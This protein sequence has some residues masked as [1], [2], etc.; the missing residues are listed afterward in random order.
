MQVIEFQTQNK[1]IWYSCHPLG[2]LCEQD[3]QD[4]FEEFQIQQEETAPV[5][6]RGN[7]VDTVEMEQAL[8]P[9][10]DQLKTKDVPYYSTSFCFLWKSLQHR[11]IDST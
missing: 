1:K 2:R 8:R 4:N 5:A 3:D 7:D 6:H 11:F 9:T 10:I